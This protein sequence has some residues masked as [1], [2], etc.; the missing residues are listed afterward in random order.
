M[1]DY[2]SSVS[3]SHLDAGCCPS[4]G[5]CSRRSL[6][7]CSCLESLSSSHRH[8]VD[9]GC[10]SFG[11]KAYCG[12]AVSMIDCHMSLFYDRGWCM[13]GFRRRRVVGAVGIL[14]NCCMVYW[15]SGPNLIRFSFVHLSPES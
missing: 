8:D 4:F 15:T 12:G 7:P 11:N 5:R 13:V 3:R 1:A 9:A 10:H 14:F 6:G 2:P